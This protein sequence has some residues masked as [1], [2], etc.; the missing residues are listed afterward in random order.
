VEFSATGKGYPGAEA[1]K[2]Q[3][4]KGCRSRIPGTVQASKIKSTM[5]LHYLYPLESSW[6]SGH[7]AITCLI[8]NSSAN[9]TS[10][11]LKAHPKG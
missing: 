3:A 5:T 2:Q 11:L 4:D 10:S 8:V 7:R 6:S 9:L 1:L